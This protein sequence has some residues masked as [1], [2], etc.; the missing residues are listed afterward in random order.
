MTA[1]PPLAPRHFPSRIADL[2]FTAD[3]PADWISH[4]LPVEEVDFSD[5]T[6]FVPLAVVTAPHAAIV[7]A[8]AARPAHAEGTLHDWTWYHLNTQPLQTRAVGRDVVAGV[9]A[10]S[11]EAAQ[12]SEL[13]PMVVRFAF[14]EDGD[15]LVQMSLTAPELFADN[16]REAWFALLRSFTLATPRGSRFAIEP[17]GDHL[18]TAPIAEPWL[19]ASPPATPRRTM[20]LDAETGEPLLPMTEVPDPLA[21]DAAPKLRIGD[22]ALDADSIAL[23]DDHA[24]NV[25]LRDRGIG[26]VPNIAGLSDSERRATLAAGAILAEFDVPYGWHVIDDGRRVLVF[27]PS[28]RI[29][30]HL[31][32]LPRQ[33]RDNA[34]MLDAIEAQMR[35]DYPA[36]VFL[37]LSEGGIDAIGARHIADGEQPL[38]QVHMLHAF[39]DE[40]MVLRARVT[41]TPEQATNA[42]N[43]A[44]FV[45]ASCVFA[46]EPEDEACAAEPASGSEPE[47][48][49]STDDGRPAWWHEAQALEATDDLEAAEQHI[50]THCPHIGFACATADLYRLRMQRLQAAGD[51]AGADDAHRRSSE[52]IHHYASLAT[53]GGEG[54]ALSME[55]DAFLAE[56]DREH[57]TG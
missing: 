28:G 22:F 3:L 16:V 52:F 11:G 51:A 4:E 42:C 2:G 38:E 39:R 27:E 9:A 35:A 41:A 45:L 6:S 5:P 21:P 37:R 13:G 10:V 26:L 57:L 12:D 29:Q 40:T 19:E 33:G 17:H 1:T 54:A 34:A 44:E 50:R 53:S 49:P 14:L 46:P 31:D 7:F 25:R 36:P 48:A 18:P 43:L 23:D 24:T 20:L 32:L 55:R 56:L 30:I 47:P 8:F 15:R